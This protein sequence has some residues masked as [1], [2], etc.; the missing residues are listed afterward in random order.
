MHCQ[1][2]KVYIIGSYISNRIEKMNLG[3]KSIRGEYINEIQMTP[4]DGPQDWVC[5]KCNNLNFSFRKKCNR[6]K[7]QSREDNEQLFYNDYYYYNQYYHYHNVQ[8]ERTQSTPYKSTE[9][10]THSQVHSPRKSTPKPSKKENDNLPSVSP[11]LKK[12]QK[13]RK[14]T[15]RKNEAVKGLWN[16]VG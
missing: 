15:H 11:L 5:Y 1:F 10:H 8:T 14:S 12:Y 6:C 16:I 3:Y 7:I 2:W 13:S 4:R 9:H